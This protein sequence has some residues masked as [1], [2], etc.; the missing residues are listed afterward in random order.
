M[1]VVKVLNLEYLLE[2][3]GINSNTYRGQTDH[4]KQGDSAGITK[5]TEGAC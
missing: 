1:N 5:C 3:K 4:L 2:I